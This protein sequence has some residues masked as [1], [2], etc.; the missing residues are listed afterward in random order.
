MLSLKRVD[1][2]SETQATGK[3]SG[4]HGYIL[5]FL[6]TN[7]MNDCLSGEHR[8]ILEFLKTSNMNDCLSSFLYVFLCFSSLEKS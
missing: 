6:T 4:E 2:L 1:R 7:N 5:E 3:D 8:Y